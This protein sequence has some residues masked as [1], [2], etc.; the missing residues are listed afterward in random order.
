M[1]FGFVLSWIVLSSFFLL[2]WKNIRFY[3]K[4]G[5]FLTQAVE[6]A[7]FGTV[8]YDHFFWMQSMEL[9]KTAKCPYCLHLC[10]N[11]TLAHVFKA[12]VQLSSQKDEFWLIDSLIFQSLGLLLVTVGFADYSVTQLKKCKLDCWT[13]AG[14]ESFETYLKSDHRFSFLDLSLA[15]S[16]IKFILPKNVAGLFESTLKKALFYF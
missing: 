3:S 11:N 6:R 4:A 12:F 2:S 9:V 8:Y 15:N 10:T 14:S 13:L 7:M 16:Y 1:F 5:F